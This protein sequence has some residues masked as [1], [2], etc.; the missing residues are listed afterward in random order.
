[1]NNITQTTKSIS[2]DEV[3]NVFQEV[4]DNKLTREDASAW[5]KKLQQA[6]DLGELTYNPKSD[7][8]AI[9]R[10]ITYLLGI[11]LPNDQGSYLHSNEDIATFINSLK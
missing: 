11:D 3:K 1:L 2:I 6:E 8:T 7:E 4:L 9:W 5:A 10:G